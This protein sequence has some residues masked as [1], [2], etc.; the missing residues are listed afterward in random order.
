MRQYVYELR[1]TSGQLLL[2]STVWADSEADALQKA[3]DLTTHA[4]YTGSRTQ[5]AVCLPDSLETKG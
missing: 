5:L 3:K 1:S 4:G 2:Q